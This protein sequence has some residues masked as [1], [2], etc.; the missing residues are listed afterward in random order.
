MLSFVLKTMTDAENQC[1]L[2]RYIYI[3]DSIT[4]LSS[5]L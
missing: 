1:E 3:M 5:F 4:V 2:E